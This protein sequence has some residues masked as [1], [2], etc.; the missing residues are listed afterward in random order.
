V[1]NL[2]VMFSA[3]GSPGSTKISAS[4]PSV[5]T[6]HHVALT[7]KSGTFTL[8]VDGASVGTS[9][10]TVVPTGTLNVSV[11]SNTPHTS[12]GNPFNGNIDEVMLSTIARYTAAF[13]PSGP[14]PP[15]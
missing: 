10:T 12:P 2:I 1:S 14:F 7:R 3:A 13:T 5:D 9:T 15:P 4:A 6:W 11:G 8:W